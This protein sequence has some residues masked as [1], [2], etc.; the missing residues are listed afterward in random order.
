LFIDGIKLSPLNNSTCS[1]FIILHSAGSVEASP[2]QGDQKRVWDR[3]PAWVRRCE[4][5][6]R[7][8]SSLD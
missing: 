3:K 1:H 2:G 5:E 7:G 6:T 4:S 8:L